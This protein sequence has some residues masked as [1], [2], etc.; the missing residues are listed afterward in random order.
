MRKKPNYNGSDGG[1]RAFSSMTG[2][3]AGSVDLDAVAPGALKSKHW[4]GWGW[5]AFIAYVGSIFAANW[6]VTTFGFVPVGF[7]LMA[8]A[9]VFLVGLTFT[10]RDMVQELLGKWASL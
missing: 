6:A 9:A 5:A 4:K 10:L 8:P 3:I 2:S 1:A 7:G